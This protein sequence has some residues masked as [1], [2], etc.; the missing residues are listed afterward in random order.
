MVERVPVLI[1]SWLDEPQVARIREA[2]PAR[3]EVLYAPDLL[4]PPRYGADHTAPPRALSQADLGRWRAMLARAEISFDFDWEQPS[5]LPERAP[6]LRWLQ[7]TS[8]GIGPKVRSTGLLD[9]PVRVT[10]AAGIHAQPL[11]E[12]ALLA[13]LYFVRE[14]PMLQRLQRAHEW[15][16]YCGD[17]LASRRMLVIGM[18]RVGSRVAE[19]A[20]AVG[21]E[22]WGS[23]RTVTPEL[24]TGVSRMIHPSDL[25]AALAQVHVVVLVLP[26]NASTRHLL[27]RR[28]LALLPRG[29][30]IVNIGRGSL[31]D[32]AALLDALRSGHLLGAALDVFQEEPLP[33]DSPFWDE[34]N[35][36]VAPHSAST[37]RQENDRLVDLFIENLRRYLDGRPLLNL[38]TPD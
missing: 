25:D 30:V 5:R 36:L 21:M 38:W 37:V 31:I 1:S 18:G 29:S 8:S 23:R 11:A 14:V 20:A 33:P 17:E 10:N 7:A 24:P 27:D 15:T 26:D 3:V 35:V 4:P 32:E 9:G 28:R 22:V 19:V 16:R 34:P 6:R 2:E 13:A 12:F